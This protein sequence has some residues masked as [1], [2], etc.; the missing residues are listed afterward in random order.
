MVEDITIPKFD[1]F[2]RGR[3]RNILLR[4]TNSATCPG[5]TCEILDRECGFDGEEEISEDIWEEWVEQAE[6]EAKNLAGVLS[7]VFEEW[8]IKATENESYRKMASAILEI[9]RI[10]D[11]QI[12]DI[13]A[14]AYD[15]AC[16][17]HEIQNCETMERS[18]KS[19]IDTVKKATEGLLK[20]IQ[21]REQ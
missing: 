19:I 13:N 20:E 12:D 16:R 2:H 9:M 3:I 14:F 18:D 21:L 4:T 17:V 10:N 11:R 15:V 1:K 7:N 6:E 5:A 8:G